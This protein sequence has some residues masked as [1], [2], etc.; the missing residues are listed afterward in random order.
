MIDHA[1]HFA[2]TKL[3]VRLLDNETGECK[4]GKRWEGERRV[5]VVDAGCA[6]STGALSLQ[7]MPCTSSM[8]EGEP[9]RVSSA[10]NVANLG[11]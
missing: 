1:I 10:C 9:V 3:V 4:I 5:V 6:A 7:I 2:C 11:T 8:A